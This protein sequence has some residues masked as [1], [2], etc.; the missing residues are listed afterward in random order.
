MNIKDK[1]NIISYNLWSG[2]DFSKNISSD[3]HFQ[4]STGNLSD[5]NTNG[6]YSV[7][8]TRSIE[9]TGNGYLQFYPPLTSEDIGKTITLTVDIYT[10]NNNVAVQIYSSTYSGVTVPKNTSFETISI[11]KVISNVPSAC[12]INLFSSTEHELDCYIDNL[13]TYIQ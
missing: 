13:R 8:I 5:H 2:G 1:N 3:Y 10:P 12:I 4:S 11:S 6:D 7:H 9:N